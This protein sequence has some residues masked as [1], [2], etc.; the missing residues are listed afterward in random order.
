[1]AA[2]YFGNEVKETKRYRLGKVLGGT[3]RH[4]LLMTATPH[5]GKEEDFQLFMALLD[6]DRFE[7]KVREGVHTADVSDLMRR[8][9]K[10]NLLRFDG[11]P[12]FPE[13]R[14]YTVPYELSDLEMALYGEVTEY[15]AEEMGRA[16]RLA[17]EG[18]GRRGNR[19]GFAVT[20]LQRRLAS[21][22]EAIYQ[23]LSRRRRR[24]E[25]KA[26]EVKAQQRASSFSP[27]PNRYESS[28]MIPM[29]TST[30]TSKIS[31]VLRSRNWRSNSSTRQRALARSQ[32]CSTR[33]RR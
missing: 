2:H 30:T 19:V 18:E 3:A 24:L 5:A 14:A 20:V 13:R 4:F 21:S 22:P 29:R 8:M 16:E 31:K 32:S 25:D 1:M 23:S 28:S 9:V 10:E 15:V 26:S 11:R 6:S 12:L 7:G 17:A 33:S 27:R